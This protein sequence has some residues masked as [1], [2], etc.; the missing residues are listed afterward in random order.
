MFIFWMGCIT[1]SPS[2][3][4]S[5]VHINNP[6]ALGCSED[7]ES[8]KEKNHTYCWDMNHKRIH[9]ASVYTLADGI[10]TFQY[11]QGSITKYS[12]K[13]TK[14]EEEEF[15]FEFLRNDAPLSL[16]EDVVEYMPAHPNTHPLKIRLFNNGVIPYSEL[17]SIPLSSI[18]CTTSDQICIKGKAFSHSLLED[19]AS[20]TIISQASTTYYD[21]YTV[22]A[23][24]VQECIDACACSFIPTASSKLTWSQASAYCTAQ[25]KRLPTEAELI[26]FSSQNKERHIFEEWT[27]DWYTPLRSNLSIEPQ[28]PCIGE[29]SCNQTETKTILAPNGTRRG[30]SLDERLSFRCI[31]STK[32]QRSQKPVLLTQKPFLPPF[33]KV[34]TEKSWHKKDSTYRA[35]VNDPQKNNPLGYQDIYILTETLWKIHIQHPSN[36]AL[37]QL[38]TTHL[39]YPI[40]ALRISNTP[41]SDTLKPALLFYGGVHGNDLMGTTQILDQIRLMLDAQN[42]RYQSFLHMSDL[43]FL[44]L[45][46]P[47]GNLHMMRTSSASKMGRKNGRST[48]GDCESTPFEGVDIQ[49]NFPYDWKE[50]NASSTHYSGPSPLSEPESQAIQKLAQRYQFLGALSWHSPGNYVTGPYANEGK[51]TPSPDIFRSIAYNMLKTENKW[52][53]KLRTQPKDPDMGTP[54]DWL[55]HNFGT[56][57]YQ[58]R[59]AKHN[60][61]ID[62]YKEKYTEKYRYIWQQFLDAIHEQPSFHGVVMNGQKDPIVAQIRILGR[63][64]KKNKFL[65]YEGEEWSARPHDGYY[66]QLVPQTGVY[67][68]EIKALGYRKTRKRIR[69]EGPRSQSNIILRKAQ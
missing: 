28:P 69:V 63:I 12:I 48:L 15:L 33:T 21:E 57:A 22:G 38:G 18:P 60:L 41:T 40:L 45:V 64:D 39:G 26:L 59:I 17:I 11:A 61:L 20:K 34:P 67:E 52:P 29:T 55:F 14:R 46:N 6:N 25:Q 66:H 43:W 8:K 62:K 19:N 51:K 16:V 2:I 56:Y 37:Y 49:R 3:P 68:I 53:P 44:P 32:A 13:E 65:Y 9:G 36:T 42:N 5:T 4:T 54:E 31:S 10:I 58:I 1:N 27:S 30:A 24:N 35:M 23:L 47:D 50:S 7:L